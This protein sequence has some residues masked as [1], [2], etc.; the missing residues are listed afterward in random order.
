VAS[1]HSNGRSTVSMPRDICTKN[2]AKA[3]QIS[4][5]GEERISLVDAAEFILEECRMVLPGIQAL[6][7]FQLIAVFNSGFREE[8]APLEQRLHLLAI[9]LIVLA[10]AM[11]MTPAA[12]HRQT[13]ANR[14]TPRFITLSTRLL[15]WSMFPL[16]VGIC[17]DFFLIARVVLLHAGLAAIL[18]AALFALLMTLWYALPH[19]RG[20]QRLLGASH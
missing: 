16:A 14:L 8:L 9:V 10:T 19:A 1:P 6:F 15:L 18:A 4:E 20:M 13:G 11:I 3:P 7:G 5:I 17:I 2:M 12:Y